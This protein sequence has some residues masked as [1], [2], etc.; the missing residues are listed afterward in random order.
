MKS[1]EKWQHELLRHKKI[2]GVKAFANA[3]TTRQAAVTPL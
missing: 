1:K 3:P 2:R